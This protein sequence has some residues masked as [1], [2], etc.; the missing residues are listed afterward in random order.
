P[1][2]RSFFADVSQFVRG[3]HWM[4]WDVPSLYGFF[5]ILALAFVPAKDGWQALFELTAVFLVAQATVVFVI[6]RWGRGGWTNTLFALLFPLAT[7]FGD[8]IARFPVSARLYPQGGMR[9]FWI[10]AL[11]FT[12]FLSYVWR[13]RARRVAALRWLG[14]GLWFAALLWSLEAGG[15]ATAVWLPYLLLDALTNGTRHGFVA[16]TV[17]LVRN[18]WPVAVLPAL[19][20]FFV[21]LF[22]KSK[23]GHAPD[24]RAYVEYTGLFTSGKV[25]SVFHVQYLGAGWILLL[26]L[27]A[28]G[29]LGIAA[30]R[31]RRWDLFRLLAGAWLAVWA[32]AS[33]YA[34]EPLDMYVALLLCVMVPAAA[35]AIFASRE[36]LRDRATSLLARYSLA[37]LAVIAIALTFGEPSRIAAMTFPFTPGWNFD[38]SQNAQPV[39]GELAA[40]MQRAGIAPGDPVLIPNGAY[41]TEPQQGL[42]QPF[43]RT[44]DGR[45]VLFGA[46]LP[47][48]PFG[49][50]TLAAALDP[51]RKSTYVER[52][53]DV[54]RAGGWYVT[55]RSKVGCESLSSHL[56][57]VSS[58]ASTNFAV[59]RCAYHP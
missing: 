16:T 57:T 32:T 33:Y 31:E 52:F 22:Y 36:G 8:G 58:V 3:G 7:I 45:L 17:R 23:L 38:V 37:P 46:W 26:V 34:L 50:G 29:A 4:L 25:R 27:A 40:L 55:Y 59:M 54:S 1:V 35:I 47:T 42:I 51:D 48:S 2:H 30:V 43:E 49:P 13:E 6:L 39:S 5:S 18:F 20:V 9:F 24:W 19:G 10:V 11:L 56:R 41:W 15:W 44:A 14:H 28:V 53:L 12:F 21:D